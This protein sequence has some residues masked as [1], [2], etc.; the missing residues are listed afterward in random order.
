MQQRLPPDYRD[1]VVYMRSAAPPRPRATDSTGLGILLFG[2][3]CAVASYIM[4]PSI[5]AAMMPPPHAVGQRAPST[6]P[7]PAAPWGNRNLTGGHVPWGY[8]ESAPR[9]RTERIPY[10]RDGRAMNMRLDPGEIS[11]NVEDR[12]GEVSPMPRQV[13][14]V[15]R[16]AQMPQPQSEP[17]Y[18]SS[19]GGRVRD[20]TGSW[21]NPFS[22]AGCGEWR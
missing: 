9:P 2:V 14:R 21:W 7:A 15:D 5:R 12:R 10:G 3:C 22:D 6:E 13:D 18:G 4:W 17:R 19:G 1:N 20:C 11:P 16:R 8:P